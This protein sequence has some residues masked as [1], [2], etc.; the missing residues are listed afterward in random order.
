MCGIVGYVGY[1]AAAPVLLDGLQRLEY[2]G[3]DSA[4]V[5]LVENQRLEVHRTAGRVVQLRRLMPTD[6]PATVGIAHT[7]WG[8][9]RRA[10]RR[11]RPSAHRQQRP[12][13]GCPQWSVGQRHRPAGPAGTRRRTADVRDR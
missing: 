12:D 11:E 7:R 6:P 9:P 5:A 2:R 8:H 3:Y 10:H 4:G 1:R 13:R